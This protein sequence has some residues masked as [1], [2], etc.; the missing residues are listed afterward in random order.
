MYGSGHQAQPKIVRAYGRQ[1]F[2]VH[3]PDHEEQARLAY[4]SAN[5]RTL[6]SFADDEPDVF[7]V[8]PPPPPPRRPDVYRPTTAKRPTAAVAEVKVEEPTSD[9]PDSTHTHQSHPPETKPIA[10]PTPVSVS[11]HADQ[12]E[13][14]VPSTPA[15]RPHHT[16]IPS[17]VETQHRTPIPVVETPIDFVERRV[18][19]MSINPSVDSPS[20][21]RYDSFEPLINDLSHITPIRPTSSATSFDL[22]TPIPARP[23]CSHSPSPSPQPQHQSHPQSQQ[24]TQ[25][26]LANLLA[27]CTTPTVLRFSD[28]LAHHGWTASSMTKIGEASYSDVFMI[29]TLVIKIMPF[30]M[31]THTTGTPASSR[32]MSARM[33]RHNR[34]QSLAHSDTSMCTNMT[35]KMADNNDLRPLAALIPELKLSLAVSPLPGFIPT[36][37]AHVVHDVYTPG[38]LDAWH[39]FTHTHPDDALNPPPPTHVPQW[40]CAVVMPFAGHPLDKVPLTKAKD[41]R[42]VLVQVAEALAVGEREV[43]FEHRD[44]HWGNVL[45]SE[46]GDVKLIDWTL[47]RVEGVWTHVPEDVFGGEGDT[48]FAVYRAMREVVEAEGAGDWSGY[49]PR[50]NVLWLEYLV[51]KLAKKSRSEVFRKAM[52]QLALDLEACGSAEQTVELVQQLP[53]IRSK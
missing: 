29:D 52:R 51:D 26:N 44:L 39:A 53:V 42:S 13:F 7:E 2:K 50:T 8:P 5:P 15:R 49:Y 19:F 37:A 48:Q 45:V 34:R 47:S 16:I 22:F 36:L 9:Q 21:T 17:T 41:V 27:Q 43:K 40:Y 33:S 14:R 25:S 35:A 24:S 4:A 32:R 6:S 31:P 28:M 20:R 11:T 23:S 10:P 18:S 1:K 30:D 38:M 3:L 12:P 46:A